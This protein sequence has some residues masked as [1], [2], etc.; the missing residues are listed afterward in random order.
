MLG[1]L[2]SFLLFELRDDPTWHRGVVLGVTGAGSLVGAT[3]A[4]V[5]R[6]SLTEERM[7]TAALGAALGMGLLMA[8]L[9]GLVAAA[10][11]AATVAIVS[12]GA[13]LAF[14]SLVQRDAPDA[15]RGRSFARFEVRFQLVWFIGAVIAVL[16]PITMR[17]GY[18]VIA[19]VAGF[20]PFSYVASLPGARHGGLED[21]TSTRLTSSNKC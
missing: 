13:K 11:M 16:L 3:L 18:L 14:D 5:L 20:A 4:P 7:L 2:T 15:N 8:W 12:T 9:G 10:L 17:I 6:R 21:R 1:F 19:G